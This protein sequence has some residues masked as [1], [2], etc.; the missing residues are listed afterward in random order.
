MT[1]SVPALLL[2][3]VHAAALVVSVSDPGRHVLAG[4]LVLGGLTARGAVHHRRAAASGPAVRATVPA[5]PRQ[6]LPPAV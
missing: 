1:R 6:R 5:P 2:T 3:L 4:L